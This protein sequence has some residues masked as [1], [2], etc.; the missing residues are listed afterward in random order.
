MKRQ[1]VVSR[2]YK[3]MLRPKRFAGAAEALV[4]NGRT[5]WRNVTKQIGGVT[6]DVAGD[7]SHVKTTRLI[8]F[9]DTPHHRLNAAHYIFRDRR[10]ADGSKREVTL[11]FRHADRFLA[12]ARDMTAKISGKAETKFEEDIKAPFV[13]LHSFSTTVVI[14]DSATFTKLGDVMRLFPDLADRIEG[15]DRN[16]PLTIVNNFTAREVVLDGAMTQIGKT[17]KVTAEWALIVWYNQRRNNG[18]PVAVELSYRY[19]DKNEEYGGGAARR[20]ANVF[21]VIQSRLK[22]WVDPKPRTKTAVAFG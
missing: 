2:E 9:L 13:S 15:A 10:A 6:L 14:S 20:A 18:K 1:K 11:K 22:Q 5:L 3:V 4:A 19:G 16:Q 17:P 7:L 12:Q 21:D 8:S